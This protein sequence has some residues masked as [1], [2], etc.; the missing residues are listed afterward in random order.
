MKYDINNGNFTKVLNWE[1]KEGSSTER[2]Y[3]FRGVDRSHE[4][5]SKKVQEYLDNY[6]YITIDTELTDENIDKYVK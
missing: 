5:Y 1:W 4:E 2:L 3:Y 6:E